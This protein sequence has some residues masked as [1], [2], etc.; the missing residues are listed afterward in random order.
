MLSRGLV[1][2]PD[3]A[4]RGPYS[5][6]GSVL[7]RPLGTRLAGGSQLLRP[8]VVVRLHCGGVVR[9]VA[10]NVHPVVLPRTPVAVHERT[11]RCP[12]L[13]SRCSLVVSAG[14]V[15]KAACD[16]EVNVMAKKSRGRTGAAPVLVIEPCDRLIDEQEAADLEKLLAALALWE[17]GFVEDMRAAEEILAAAAE[18]DA[19]ADARDRAAVERENAHDLIEFLKAGAGYGDDWPERRAADLD[20]EYARQDRAAARRDRMALADPQSRMLVHLAGGGG[21]L[22]GPP[23]VSPDGGQSRGRVGTVAQRRARWGRA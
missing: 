11:A 2:L 12:L 5:R 13:T 3:P 17:A 23:D 16:R 21:R 9:G 14:G 10:S 7:A 18:R 15:G 19:L 1:V 8:G 22:A 6:F 4:S 20:R